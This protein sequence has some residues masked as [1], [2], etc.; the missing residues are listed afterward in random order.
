M[1]TIYNKI[2]LKK[3][4][5]L[6]ML[7]LMIVLAIIGIIMMAALPNFMGVLS[8]ARSM[9][10]QAQLKHAYELEKQYFFKKAKYASDFAAIKFEA[11][12]LTTQGGNANYEYSVIESSTTT[13]TI[14]A[15]AAVD[16]DGDGEM[17]VWTINQDMNLVEV[18]PD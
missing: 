6:T 11:P 9:E 17:N 12:K 8:D 10:A 16:F 18:V 7:E 3:V 5:A 15:T 13:F 14:Q 4:Q 2:K 1:P